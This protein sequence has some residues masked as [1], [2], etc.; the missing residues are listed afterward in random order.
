[1]Q[2]LLL[3]VKDQQQLK[4]TYYADSKSRVSQMKECRNVYE[5]QSATTMKQ[6]YR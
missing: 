1:M 5:K 2:Y 6:I 3:P 4:L